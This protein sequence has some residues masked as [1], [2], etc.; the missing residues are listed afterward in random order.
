[1]RKSSI[2]KISDHMQPDGTCS[3]WLSSIGLYPEKLEKCIALMKKLTKGDEMFFGHYRTDGFNLTDDEMER[4][5]IEIPAYFRENGR[6]EPLTQVVEKRGKAKT[7]SGYLTVGSLPADK[8][9]VEV[10]PQIFHYYLETICF[11]PKVDWA[12]F[13]ESYHNYMKHETRDYITNGFADLVFAYSDSG[14][15]SISFSPNQY[16]K[17]AIYQEIENIL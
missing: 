2:P 9:T 7:Y 10:L 16:D 15:F 6:Y 11:C 1:M 4:Y 13:V 8:I 12:T 14:D 17:N 3:I 5:G